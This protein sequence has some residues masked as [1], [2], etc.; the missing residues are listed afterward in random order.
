MLAAYGAVSALPG[1]RRASQQGGQGALL[2][3]QVL[4][5]GM[6]VACS[7]VWQP[8]AG[9]KSEI[10]PRISC[11]LVPRS[12]VESYQNTQFILSGKQLLLLEHAHGS[13]SVLPRD[14]W[15]GGAER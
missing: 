5:K 6:V 9:S 1:S 10:E 15:S 13:I 12:S 8:R 7:A 4:R 2:R 3:A 14:A 11:V